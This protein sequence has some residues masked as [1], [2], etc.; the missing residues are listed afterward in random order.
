MSK[1]PRFRRV[2][3]RCL[4]GLT[5]L[6]LAAAGGTWWAHRHLAQLIAASFNRTYPGLELSAKA[7][8]LTGLGELDL[9]SV[10]V[11]VRSDYSEVLKV[12]VAKIRFSW[13]G[14]RTH[15]I[16]EIVVERPA[17]KLTDE[18][19]AALPASGKA[20]GGGTPWGIGHLA[21]RDGTAKIAL[22]AWPEA[23][24]GFR[25]EQSGAAGT[26]EMEVMNLSVRT[27]PDGA[28]VL[29]LPSLKVRASLADLAARKIREVVVERV[30]K[31]TG[32]LSTPIRRAHGT[33]WRKAAR[34]E[35]SHRPAA[36]QGCRPRARIKGQVICAVLC[37]QMHHPLSTRH[38]PP[39][40]GASRSDWFNHALHRRK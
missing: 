37:A 21:I 2:L 30:N 20:G 12:P 18:L 34:S 26:N 11:R 15:F 9:K 13:S 25:I 14:L 31:G 28:E 5:L 24:F 27:R 1:P 16:R 4:L 8:V 40:A 7:V 38:Q 33:R 10:R 3:R 17:G 35:T 39:N 23:R 32:P 36:A 29:A 22:A 6:L 19:L